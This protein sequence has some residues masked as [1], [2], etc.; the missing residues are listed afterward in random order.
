MRRTGNDWL[1]PAMAIEGCGG[2]GMT[3]E[4]MGVISVE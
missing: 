2:E 3:K 4:A 1:S